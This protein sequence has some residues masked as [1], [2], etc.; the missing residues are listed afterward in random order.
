MEVIVQG[1]LLGGL[2]GAVALGLSLVF[3]VMGMVNLAHGDLLLLGA[4]LTSVVLGRFSGEP[5]LVALPV[6][7]ALALVAYPVQ[8]YLFSP[9]M[10]HGQEAPLTATFG[11]S[12]AVQTMLLLVFTSN[13]RIVTASYSNVALHLG[14]VQIRLSLLIATLIAVVLAFGLH[15]LLHR[16]HFGSQVRASTV[17]PEAALLVGIDLRRTYARVFAIAAGIAAVAGALIAT[18]FAVS[19]ASDATWLVRAFTAIVIGGLGSIRGTLIGGFVVGLAEAV[20]AWLVGPQYRDVVVF[21]L[22]VAILLA[23]PQGLFARRAVVAR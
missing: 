12:I 9:L 16:T 1:L 3:G 15:H 2:Y 23:R 17:D 4:Y 20:G 14:G 5:L 6:A 22:L 11:V 21:G 13:P 18:S 8:R 10:A 19:P 7:V